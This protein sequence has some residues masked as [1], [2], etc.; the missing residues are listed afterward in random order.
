MARGCVSGRG[1]EGRGAATPSCEA[2]PSCAPEDRHTG[3]GQGT[4]VGAVAVSGR[5][6]GGGK[7]VAARAFKFMSGVNSAPLGRQRRGKWRRRPRGRVQA[8]PWRECGDRSR[9]AAPWAGAR[10]VGQGRSPGPEGYSRGRGTRD[11]GGKWVRGRGQSGSQSLK[12]QR[13]KKRRGGVRGGDA[14][15]VPDCGITDSVLKGH[16]ILRLFWEN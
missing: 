11:R 16:C 5:G 3:S 8:G 4:R 13:G 7:P 10:R 9:E 2:R 14:A 12:M 1:D 15:S 6:H